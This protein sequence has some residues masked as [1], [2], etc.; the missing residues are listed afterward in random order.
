MKLISPACFGLFL[1][2]V[3][4]SANGQRDISGYLMDRNEELRLAATAGPKSITEGASYYVLGESGFVRATEGNNGWHCYVERAWFTPPADDGEGFDD[5]VR[6]PHCIN[7]E[8]SRTRLQE[9]FRS[10]ELAIQGLSRDEVKAQIDA[11]YAAGKLRL[12]Q[13]LA[14]TYMMSKHQ[15]LGTGAQNWKPHM[16]LWIPYLTND[17]IGENAFMSGHPIITGEPGSR[18]TVLVIPVP[19]FIE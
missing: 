16:M 1:L 18:G 2:T 19:E 3:Q 13:T 7:D 11:E 12:P 6:A 15:W 10:T 4:A 8:G 14:M 17:E 5:R 9:S